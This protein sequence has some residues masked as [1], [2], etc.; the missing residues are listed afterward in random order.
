MAKRSANVLSER[1]VEQL[2]R[3]DSEDSLSESDSDSSA[4]SDRAL[5]DA[6]EYEDSDEDHSVNED[7]MWED[8]ES[9]RGRRENFTGSV[10]P[11]GL[12]K[13]VTDI[14]KLFELFFD[15]A[16]IETIVSE[17]NK[18]AEQSLR[19]REPP[20]VRH[21]RSHGLLRQRERFML[22]WVYLCL[23]ASFRS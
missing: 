22:F 2:L 9:F 10:G 14:V 4:T 12:A 18:Y 8:M 11:Q 20:S 5:I 23:W 21:I 16:I 1:D 6:V 19:G 7:F 13:D 15:K 3:S 17:T